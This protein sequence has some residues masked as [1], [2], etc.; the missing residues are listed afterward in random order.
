MMMSRLLL[1]QKRRRVFPLGASSVTEG[2]YFTP[3]TTVE[4]VTSTKIGLL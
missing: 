1:K 2:S 4:P 3:A